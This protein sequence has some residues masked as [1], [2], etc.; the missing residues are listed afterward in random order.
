MALKRNKNGQYV[1]TSKKQVISALTLMAELSDEI[2]ALMQKHEIQEMQ[3]DAVELKKAADRYMI[4]K[5]INA[6]DLGDG[7]LAKV[8]HSAH[9]RH[10]VLLD[11][12]LAEERIPGAKSLR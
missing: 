12:E 11:E 9:D 6:L 2:A 5:G 8:V 4:D 7:R 3:Q 10:W 1:L